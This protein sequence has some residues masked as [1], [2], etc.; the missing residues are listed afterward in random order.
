MT[1]TICTR[2]T[3]LTLSAWRRRSIFQSPNT[4]ISEWEEL[5]ATASMSVPT[6]LICQAAPLAP[7]SDS[8]AFFIR[9]ATDHPFHCLNTSAESPADPFCRF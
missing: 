6:H 1:L 8:H 2:H 9:F 5:L 7:L 3:T 4:G